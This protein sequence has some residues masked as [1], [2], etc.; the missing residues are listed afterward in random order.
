[1]TDKLTR[2]DQEE[3]ARGTTYESPREREIC[4]ECGAET[5]EGRCANCADYAHMT[6]PTYALETHECEREYTWETRPSGFT[7]TTCERDIPEREIDDS[8]ACKAMTCRAC[9]FEERV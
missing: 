6:S 1:M 9:W 4:Q 3:L 2:H 8:E 7:C 5:D